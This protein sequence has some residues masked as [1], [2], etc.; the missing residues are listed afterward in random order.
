MGFDVVRADA[1]LTLPDVELMF[2]SCPVVLLG[3][4]VDVLSFG[5]SVEKHF[6]W[7]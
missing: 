3:A 2:S 1:V 7:L 6:T 5:W 4:R